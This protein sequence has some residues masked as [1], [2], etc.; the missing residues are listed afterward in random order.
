LVFAMTLLSQNVSAQEGDARPDGGVKC[1]VKLRVEFLKTGEV[2]KIERIETTCEGGEFGDAEQWW[3]KAEKAARKIEFKPAIRNG[4]PVTVTKIVVFSFERMGDSEESPD[5]D[6]PKDDN[7]PVSGRELAILEKPEAAYPTGDGSICV[8]GT[9]ILR[10]T[11]MADG[12]IGVVSVVKGL[13]YGFN[14]KAVE[15]ARQIAF[16]PKE[17]NGVPVTVNKIV[18]YN[19]TIY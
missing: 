18:H 14:E 6:P 7:P 1:A 2:R 10:V 16:V 17:V 4:R 5:A 9:V 13:P 19:F 15:A 8:R 3:K 11:F 12:N